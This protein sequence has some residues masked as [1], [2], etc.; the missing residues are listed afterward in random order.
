MNKLSILGLGLA[1]VVASMAGCK[2]P[3]EEPNPKKIPGGG[4]GPKPTPEVITHKNLILDEIFY[5]GTWKKAE[6][7]AARFAKGWKYEYDQ[8]IKITNPTS[9]PLYL[10]GLGLA[11]SHFQSNAMAGLSTEDN[12]INSHFGVN[13]IVQFPGTGKEHKV[14]PGQ[15]VIVAG[16]A[17]DHRKSKD[18]EEGE[19]NPASLDLSGAQFE[20]LSAKQFEYEDKFADNESVPNMIPIYDGTSDYTDPEETL[21]PFSI[22]ANSAVALVKLPAN[23]RTELQKEEYQWR[24][25]NTQQNGHHHASG[26]CIKLPNELVLDAVAL[27]PQNT[28]RWH[29]LSTT[30][31][32]SYTSVSLEASTT[33]EKESGMAVV[34]KRDGR[35]I[36]D[37]NDS[38]LD[39]EPQRASLFDKK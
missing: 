5:V 12:F 27:C 1:L 21:E 28:F 14:D 25:V 36:V 16:R 15:S 8:Y 22:G 37:T 31:D 39:F 24:Y 32:K 33:N 38:K 17:C 4:E 3:G 6:G 35:Q 18:G 9:E 20:W 29:V 26:R 30:L 23:P 19:Y 2:K 13:A 34:R 10:D 7:G 11:V